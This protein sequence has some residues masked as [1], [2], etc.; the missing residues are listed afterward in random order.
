MVDSVVDNLTHRTQR[1][2]D[3]NLQVRQSATSA[4][5]SELIDAIRSY[6]KRK[7]ILSHNVFFNDITLHA[8][9]ITVEYFT[10][11][12]SADDFNA[13]RQ[14]VNLHIIRLLEE[15]Q[16]ELASIPAEASAPRPPQT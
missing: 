4:Q 10:E 11:P 6:L 16:L 7:D 2:G 3:L 13:I 5:L 12:V 15:K 8:Y 1:R 14:E 9:N